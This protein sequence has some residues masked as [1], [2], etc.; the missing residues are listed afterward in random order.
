[1]LK[2]NRAFSLI[3]LLVVLGIIGILA[4]IAIPSYMGVQKKA[5]R[6]EFKTNLEVL[7]LLEE[8]HHSERGTYIAGANTDA[9]RL[10]LPEFKPGDSGELRYSYSVTVSDDGQ[11]FVAKAIGNAKS[12][13]DQG[14][15]FCLNQDNEKQP[16]ADCQSW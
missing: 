10:A 6:S 13:S 3:E 12:G 8:K 5:M 11:S 16:E 7:R 14:L 2:Q 9:L 15:A 1:M 4:A